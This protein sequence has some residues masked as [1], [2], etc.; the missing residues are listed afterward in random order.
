MKGFRQDGENNNRQKMKNNNMKNEK[1]DECKLIG[2]KLDK[3]TTNEGGKSSI[4]CG[5]LWQK[6]EKGNFIELISDKLGDE[7]YAVYF[8]YEGDSTKP[9]SYFIGCKVEI[10]AETPQGMD[11]LI[12]PT[13][14][15]SK[16]I[17]SGKMPDC[18]NNSWKDIWSSEIARTYLFDYEVYDERSN[19][20]SNA[21]VDIFVSCK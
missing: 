10:D 4:E 13:G 3:K 18:I 16:V 6:F 15:Y 21:V 12:I 17:A 5:N 8:E 2:L 19:D 1:K 9:F 11:S 20:W 14:N 7:I